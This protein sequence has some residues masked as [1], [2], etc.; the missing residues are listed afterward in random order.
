VDP[1]RWTVAHPPSREQVFNN[2]DSFALAFD[3]AWQRHHHAGPST[4]LSSN[5]TM[6][7]IIDQLR[8]H[9]FCV[10]QP[11]V[12]REVAAFRLRLLNL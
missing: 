11:S 6:E 9:P 10:N 8:D 1:E 3:E 5:E 4:A 7:L 12:A 2:A